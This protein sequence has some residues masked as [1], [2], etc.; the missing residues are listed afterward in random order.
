MATV[1]VKCPYCESSEVMR[2]GKSRTNVQRYKCKHCS[3]LFQL[4]YKN[5]AC[6][7]GTHKQI[8]SMTMNSSGVRDIAR[9]LGI[10]KNTVTSVLKKTKDFVRLRVLIVKQFPKIRKFYHLS[11]LMLF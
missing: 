10:S 6:K 2:Y 3:K 9:T 11:L 7:P 8:I 1:D 5:K 4:D